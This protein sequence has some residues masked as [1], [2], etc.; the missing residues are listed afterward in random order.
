MGAPLK[1]ITYNIL[2]LKRRF[3]DFSQLLATERPAVAALQETMLRENQRAAIPGYV[4]YRMDGTRPQRGLALYVRSDLQASQATIPPL[5]FEAQ[6]VYLK[7]GAADIM[8]VNVYLSPG[9]LLP[10]ADLRILLQQNAAML[11]VG[12]FNAHHT[13]WHCQFNSRRG[14]DLLD[15]ITSEDLRVFFPDEPTHYPFRQGQRPSVLDFGIAQGLTFGFT[16]KVVHSLDSDHLPVVFTASATAA[17]QAPLPLRRNYNKADWGLY[18]SVLDSNLQIRR[19]STPAELDAGVEEFTAAIQAAATTAIPSISPRVGL[20]LPPALRALRHD[21]DQARRRWQRTRDRTDR[22]NYLQL[23]ADFRARLSEHNSKSWEDTINCREDHN[24]KLWRI[25]R[26]LRRDYS[27]LPPLRTTQGVVYSHLDKAEALAAASRVDLPRSTDPQLEATVADFI[28]RVPSMPVHRTTKLTTPKELLATIKTLR[29]HRAPGKDGITAPLLRELSRKAIVFLV[30]LINASLLLRHFPTPWKEA[31]TIFLH[32]P[33]KDSRDP[34]NYRGISLLS[35]PGKILEKVIASR[36]DDVTERLR[37]IPTHQHGFTAGKGCITQLHRV[38]DELIGHLNNRRAITMVSLDLSKAFDSVW[39]EGLLYKLHQMHFPLDLVL[40]LKSYLSGR[41]FCARVGSTISSQ[42]D[43]QCG[44]PQ[45]S[46]LGPKL[47]VL[48]TADIPVRHG[49]MVATYADDTALI[50]ASMN[51][52]RSLQLAQSA[53]DDTVGYYGRWK[54]KNNATKTQAILFGKHRTRNIPRLTSEGTPIE[55]TRALT[56]LGITLDPM[57]RFHTHIQLAT[58]KATRA[59]GA[60]IALLGM[61]SKLQQD[62]KLRL[63][64][65]CIRPV[66]T[67]G[68]PIWHQYLSNASWDKLQLVQNIAVKHGIG[69][70]RFYS[71]TRAHEKA[72]IPLVQDFSTSIYHRHHDKMSTHVDRTLR[73]LTKGQ[74]ICDG[75]LRPRPSHLHHHRPP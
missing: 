5:S 47:F 66:L 8:V 35:I 19:F 63:Y 69:E 70:N 72:D 27:T 52:E 24:R 53:L 45:G 7:I 4:L 57:L 13:S 33:G 30:M 31:V 10:T 22:Q 3:R 68:A 9:H 74:F 2:G 1:I 17:R 48:F 16:T 67:Y 75:H 42:K 21:R 6:A 46:I 26:Y 11:L 41:T 44:V 38:V 20:I 25:A 40:L 29:P 36:L 55:W 14:K 49:R 65:A 15:L 51:R 56:Y 18:H 39:H 50:T 54:L 28:D 71:T 43:L 62:L 32:K 73:K 37:S 12:D 60:L 61:R 34:S 58:R 64:K 23:A 59:R